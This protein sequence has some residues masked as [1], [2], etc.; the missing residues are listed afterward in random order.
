MTQLDLGLQAKAAGLARVEAAHPDFVPMMRDAAKVMSAQRG[1]VHIDD[2]RVYADG[3]GLRPRHPNAWGAILR[4]PGWVKIGE[5]A[6]AWPSNHGHVSP[7]WRWV[8]A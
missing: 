3:L 4:G 8:G 7:I 1:S 5:R 6:S 2:L